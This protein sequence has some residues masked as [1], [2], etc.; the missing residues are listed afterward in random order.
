MAERSGMPAGGLSGPTAG[1]AFAAL[2]LLPMGAAVAS[3]LEPQSLWK[4]IG[5]GLGLLG[6]ALLFL[7]FPS[8]GRF[9]RLSGRIGIDRTMGFHRLSALLLLLAVSLHP[10]AYAV[11]AFLRSPS[12]GLARLQALVTNGRLA[13]GVAALALLAVLVVLASLRTRLPARYELWRVSHGPLAVVAAGLVLHHLATVGNYSAER[14]VW[15]AWMVLAA[16]AA[17]S[18]LL[19]YVA[20]P[21][22]MARGGWQVERVSQAADGVVELVLRCAPTATFCFRGGQFVWLTVAPNRPPFHD[23]PY[24]IASGPAELP[25]LRLLVREVGDCT[26]TYRDLAPG[27]HVALDGPH[28]SFVLPDEPKGVA[29]IAGGVGI[30]PLLGILEEAAAR[31]DRRPFRLL[32]AA[33]STDAMAGSERLEALQDRLDLRVARHA[34]RSG[35]DGNVKTSP[36]ADRELDGVVAGLDPETTVAMVCGPP[37]LMEKVTDR[38]LALGLP[39]HSVLYE[40]FD[41]AG[42][43]GRLDRM[44]R[45]QALAVLL[46]LLAA[47]LLFALR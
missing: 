27:T 11:P 15:V 34:D 17:I 18:A 3:G 5:A 41:Y 9:E 44:R 10:I 46:P 12:S 28:G 35:E 31:G 6:G 29:M 38:L 13:T 20:R 8:S 1:F 33:R 26:T 30:A 25:L 7:Q 4:E 16:I 21:W 37:Q 32:Y 2:A 14:L 39:P 43:R 42:G 40:R 45:R 22:Q 19:T 36:L 24:S 23:H 47:A